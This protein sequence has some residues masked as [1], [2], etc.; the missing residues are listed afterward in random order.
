[1]LNNGKWEEELDKLTSI[2]DKIPLDKTIKWGTQVYT[3][4][5][6]NVLSFGGFK[7]FFSLWFFNGV[8]LTDTYKVLVNASEGKTKSLRQWR[9]KHISEIDE[10]KILEYINEAI[11][12]EKKGLK[13]APKKFELLDWPD[14]LKN[15]LNNNRVLLNAFKSLSPGKQNEFVLYLNEAKLEATKIKR[16]EKIIPL[17]MEGKGINDRYK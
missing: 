13:I 12:V 5:G 2:V 9:F 11:E 1:M 14:I 7:N 15:E 10:E 6:N 16:M 3:Y 8:F 17:I 4:N